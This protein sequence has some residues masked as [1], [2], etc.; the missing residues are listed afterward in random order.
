MRPLVGEATMIC[1][2]RL[3]NTLAVLGICT[4]SL[5]LAAWWWSSDMPGEALSLADQ[6]LAIGGTGIFQVC[7][8]VN[9][10]LC[11]VCIPPPECTLTSGGLCV[12]SQSGGQ[13]GCS[14]PGPAWACVWAYCAWCNDSA[15]PGWCGTSQASVCPAPVANPDGTFDC[16]DGTC[17]PGGSVHCDSC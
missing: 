2:V 4:T 11:P 6:Q 13:D 14:S 9:N 10:R 12:P 5:I 16:P 8:L 17:T 1:D 3:R 7:P 15:L